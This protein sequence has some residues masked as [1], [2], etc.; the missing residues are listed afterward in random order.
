MK[1]GLGPSHPWA[2]FQMSSNRVSE[3]VAAV[4]ASDAEHGDPELTLTFKKMGPFFQ[5]SG[6]IAGFVKI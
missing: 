5:A 3:A 6:I 4:G 2:S 1:S